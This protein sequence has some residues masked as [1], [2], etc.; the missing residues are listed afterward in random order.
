M[1]DDRGASGS[2]GSTTVG[3]LDRLHPSLR[4]AIVHELGW[5]ALRPVQDLAVN[6]IVDGHNTVILAPTAGGKTE[7]SIFPVLSRILDERD[8]EEGGDEEVRALYVCP[9]RALLNNQEER[10]QSYAAM[11]GLR[12]FKWHG[13][14]GASQKKGFKREPTSILMTTPESLEVML[15]SERTDAATLFRKLRAIVVDEIHAFAADDRGAHL[16]S[17]LERLRRFCDR[18]LQRIGLSATVGNPATIGAWLQGSSERSFVLVDPPKPAAEREL[19][20]ELTADLEEAASAARGLGWGKK[21]LVFVESRAEAE[22]LAAAM[23]VPRGDDPLRDELQVFVHH[24]AVSRADRQLAEQQFAG[25]RN[26]AIVC[27]STMELGIDVGDLDL[28]MQLGAPSTVASLLQRMGRTG[29]RPGTRSNYRFFCVGDETLLQALALVRLMSRGWVEDVEPIAEAAHILAHQILALSLQEGGVSRHRVLQHIAPAYCFRG[30]DPAD[31]DALVDTMVERRILHESDGLLS[32]GEDGERRYGRQNFFELYAVFSAPSVVRVMYRRTEIGT[33]QS[34]FIRSCMDREEGL[35]FRLA[36]RSWAVTHVEL[37]RGLVQVVPAARGRVPSWLGF[38]SMLSYELCQEMKRALAADDSPTWLTPPA[39]RELGLLR[40]S[41]E[42]LV[43]PG[44]APIEAAGGSHQW[45]TFAGGAINRLLASALED[46]GAGKWTAGNLTLK[47][48]KP[49]ADAVVTD[50]LARL[51]DVDWR[52]QARRY[53]ARMSHLQVSKFQ[54]CLPEELEAR[55][56]V[57]R[58]TD[59]EG[60]VRFVRQHGAPMLR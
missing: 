29:R 21:S 19:A 16:V 54:V 40:R 23:H 12:A 22:R 60:T 56:L 39:R 33:V 36:G 14:V 58:L 1:A 47:P 50:A 32:L 26:T 42:G 51:R 57:E 7:A 6:A 38:P 2:A 52:A 48:T 30:L 45:H 53:V 18:D 25:G 8:L 27:T 34:L 37:D 44:V 4:H 10:I 17:I 24:S 11:V 15:I 31:V 20:I 13:D 55:L 41:Y 28:V 5:R 46:L 49:L 43:E 3:A 9:I 35:L 59:V